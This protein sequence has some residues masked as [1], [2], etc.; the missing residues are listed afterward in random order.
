MF[1]DNEYFLKWGF[2]LTDY[3]LRS[4]RQ[5][6]KVRLGE[7]GVEPMN[8]KLMVSGGAVRAPGYY[9]KEGRV[10]S[11]LFVPAG[12]EVRRDSSS[13]KHRASPPPRPPP[14]ASL[15]I[16]IEYSTQAPQTGQRKQP[17]VNYNRQVTRCYKKKTVE[18]EGGERVIGR[19]PALSLE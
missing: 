16:C 6:I 10:E 15:H 13:A 17:E 11:V 8:W 14:P 5:R 2:R 4:M 7:E 3:C 18:E 12:E 19:A 1:A 9:T